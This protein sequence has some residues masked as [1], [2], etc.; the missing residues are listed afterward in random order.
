[1]KQVLASI[2][3]IVALSATLAVCKPPVK[4]NPQN[5]TDPTALPKNVTKNVLVIGTS[6]PFSSTL[7]F[8]VLFFCVKF[9]LFIIFAH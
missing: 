4:I 1:M 7:V 2:L 6:I 5:P 8:L 3:C 9:N